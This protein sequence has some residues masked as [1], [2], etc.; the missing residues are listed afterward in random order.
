MFQATFHGRTPIADQLLR[1]TD[2]RGQVIG[3]H[4]AKRMGGGI[5]DSDEWFKIKT[6][7]LY[8]VLSNFNLI[9]N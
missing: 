9:L 7:V 1:G 2:S 4:K 6:G 8:E 3:P 5:I